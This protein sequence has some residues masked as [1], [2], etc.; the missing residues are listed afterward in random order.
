MTVKKMTPQELAD[1]HWNWLE[2]ILLE[3]MRMQM[4]L[5]KDGF[6]HGHKHGYE[7]GKKD[8]VRTNTSTK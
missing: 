7:E 5:Y 1:Q 8:G 3:S 2:G 4:K 6:I